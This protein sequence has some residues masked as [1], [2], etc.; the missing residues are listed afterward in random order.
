MAT[1]VQKN[2]D[3]S[4]SRESEKIRYELLAH[5]FPLISAALG[6][7]PPTRGECERIRAGV[8]PPGWN[9]LPN[10]SGKERHAYYRMGRPGPKW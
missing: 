3:R 4:I 5:M 7:T 2:I 9:L 10:G 8:L 1:W 6:N